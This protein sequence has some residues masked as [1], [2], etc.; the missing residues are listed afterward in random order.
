MLIFGGSATASLVF[1]VT[2]GK[3]NRTQGVGLALSAHTKN[4]VRE[5]G[6]GLVAYLCFGRQRKANSFYRYY[7]FGDRKIFF[8]LPLN[9]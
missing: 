5:A 1:R 4:D 8:E 3:G 9:V 7:S 6:L 2:A